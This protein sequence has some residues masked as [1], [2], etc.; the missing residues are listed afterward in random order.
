[1]AKKSHG[2]RIK[3]RYKLRKKVRDRGIKIRRALQR[4]E[5]G[6]RVHVVIDPSVQKG[7]P[8]PRFH[9][10]TGMVVGERGKS[11]V[12]EITDGGKKKTLIVRPEHLRLQEV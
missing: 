10:R 2:L 1:M 12:V 8:H 7:M 5:V 11:Y 3:S 9:G 4:F 6:Q